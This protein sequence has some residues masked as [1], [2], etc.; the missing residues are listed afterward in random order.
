MANMTPGTD[1]ATVHL[2]T[3]TK[4]VAHITSADDG[5][6]HAA[7][8]GTM[9]AMGQEAS[10]QYTR[11]LLLLQ[12][13]DGTYPS[14]TIANRTVTLSAGA[15]M[16][17]GRYI[18]WDTPL[19][20][21]IP[22]PPSGTY[23]LYYAIAIKY[24]R[25][26]SGIESA[27][28][29]MIPAE[30]DD[31]AHSV[32]WGE[33]LPGYD[34][35][36]TTASTTS[37]VRMIGTVQGYSSYVQGVMMARRMW[38]LD[39]TQGMLVTDSLTA[40]EINAIPGYVGQR[41]LNLNEGIPKEYVCYQAANYGNAAKWVKRAST[42]T[43]SEIMAQLET[44]IDY[45]SEWSLSIDAAQIVGKRLFLDITLTALSIPSVDTCGLLNI[46]TYGELVAYDD[47]AYAPMFIANPG[48]VPSD[49]Q[50]INSIDSSL[51]TW[52]LALTDGPSATAYKRSLKL[53]PT[54]VRT[55][56]SSSVAPLGEGAVL[57]GQISWPLTKLIV[58]D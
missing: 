28:I 42:W 36:I 52:S 21:D 8:I 18:R 25:D 35:R 56:S 12:A 29:T 54:R 5:A 30:Y 11:G 2:V 3:G 10:M 45:P 40:D 33:A 31:V 1:E 7:T 17:D 49:A 34:N 47:T 44:S 41:L 46:D 9:S 13:P 48:T 26:A 43:K 50:I 55:A 38:P 27:A 23:T 20:W 14:I 51:C 58:M 22:Y 16:L 37:T 39:M 19:S 57:H 53:V 15:V 32:K 6:M 4:G 24:D